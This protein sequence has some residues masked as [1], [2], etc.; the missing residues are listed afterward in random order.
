MVKTIQDFPEV[1]KQQERLDKI[2][3]EIRKRETKLRGVLDELEAGRPPDEV[4]AERALLVEAILHGEVYDDELALRQQALRERHTHLLAELRVL[5]SV[6]APETEALNRSIMA[7]S[8]DYLPT[9][10]PGFTVRWRAWL[11][12]LAEIEGE[13]RAIVE[14]LQELNR[15]GWRG[16]EHHVVPFPYAL[17]NATRQQSELALSRGLITKAE[18][19]ALLDLA[20][21]PTH[22]TPFVPSPAG[23]PPMVTAVPC[24]VLHGRG[25]IAVGREV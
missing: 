5:R 18:R 24:G 15:A 10:R 7:A 2:K 20:G 19:E 22:T 25:D 11:E 21:E 8:Q 16:A 13:Q 6:L 4:A 17:G 9:L 14:S 23:P 1:V 12:K 3:S